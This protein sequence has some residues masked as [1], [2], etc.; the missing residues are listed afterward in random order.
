MMQNNRILD[1]D[2]AFLAGFTIG[3]FDLPKSIFGNSGAL[4]SSIR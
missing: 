2:P 3:R 4:I 1:P